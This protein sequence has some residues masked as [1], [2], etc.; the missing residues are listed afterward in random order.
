MKRL[1]LLGLWTSIS[2]LVLTQSDEKTR[3]ARAEAAIQPGPGHTTSLPGVTHPRPQDPNTS[4]PRLTGPTIVVGLGFGVGFGDIYAKG[5]S[6]SA[7]PIPESFNP[8]LDAYASQLPISLGLGYRPIPHLSFGAALGIAPLFLKDCSSNCSGANLNLG[9]EL[10]L[11]LLPERSFSHWFSIGFGYEWF[12]YLNRG[13]SG[14]Y[15]G[16]VYLN[17]YDFDFQAGTDVRVTPGWTIG[18]YVDLR[19]GT[20]GH[21]MLRSAFRGGS[22]RD[23]DIPTPNHA[24]HAWLTFGVRG[25]YVL[26]TR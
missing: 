9:G 22:D 11:H 12:S 20:Y 4:G 19:A 21:L 3:S 16:T 23:D 10:R 8:S 6:G 15:P 18:P 2:G 1:A 26:Y 13:T 5:S 25:A 17:G 24:T 14:A 7:S